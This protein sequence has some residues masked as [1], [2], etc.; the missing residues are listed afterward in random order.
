MQHTTQPSLALDFVLRYYLFLFFFLSFCIPSRI[1]PF[2]NLLSFH[3]FTH[4]SPFIPP[5]LPFFFIC[6]FLSQYFV[7]FISLPSIHSSFPKSFNLSNLSI[8]FFH[9]FIYFPFQVSFISLPFFFQNIHSSFSWV[10]PSNSFLYF[11]VFWFAWCKCNCILYIFII[12][13]L[14]KI[15]TFFY[16]YFYVGET[17]IAFV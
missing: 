14:F 12:N 9:P 1:L 11:P 16:I 13:I 7:F 8:P 5:I 2:P 6:F 3:I 15:I 4:S 17:S 10:Y